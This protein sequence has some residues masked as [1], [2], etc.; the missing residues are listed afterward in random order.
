MPVCPKTYGKYYKLH[1]FFF[2]HFYYYISKEIL[3]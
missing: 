1:A 3:S 2:M